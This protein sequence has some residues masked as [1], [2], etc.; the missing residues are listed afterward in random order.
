LSQIWIAE[1]GP[2][3]KIPVICPIPWIARL[4]GF[5][6]SART[7]AAGTDFHP[8]LLSLFRGP[9]FVKIG[10][11]DFLSFVMSVTYIMPKGWPFSADITHFCHGN[12]SI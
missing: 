11:L 6:D 7:E 8:N 2:F 3:V 10:V 5:D 12:S 9:D 1:A 4:G